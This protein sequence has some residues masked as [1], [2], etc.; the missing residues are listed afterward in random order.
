MK[1]LSVYRPVF[2]Q[3]ER[4][5]MSESK[6]GY[7]VGMLQ[8]LQDVSDWQQTMHEVE[9]EGWGVCNMWVLIHK[10][11]RIADLPDPCPMDMLKRRSEAR[12]RV[13]IRRMARKMGVELC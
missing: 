2:T 8:H 11:G 13:F 7:V 5:S 9:S 10:D 4:R 1:S 12:Q 3:S 6:D